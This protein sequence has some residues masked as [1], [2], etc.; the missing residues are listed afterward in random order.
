MPTDWLRR[1]AS[2]RSRR[3]L[4]PPGTIASAHDLGWPPRGATPFTRSTKV[5]Q[6]S[7]ALVSLPIEHKPIIA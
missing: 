3:E 7:D 2:H 1:A 6:A 4:R 5:A